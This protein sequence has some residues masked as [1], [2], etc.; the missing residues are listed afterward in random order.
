MPPVKPDVCV[1]GDRVGVFIGAGYKFMTVEQAVDLVAKINASVDVIQRELHRR[2]R[3]GNGGIA[4]TE[5]A[6]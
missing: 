6:A 4:S 3:V 1:E 5:Y 2:A